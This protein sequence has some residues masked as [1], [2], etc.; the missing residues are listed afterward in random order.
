MMT[1]SL[2]ILTLA[3][4]VQAWK[5]MLADGSDNDDDTLMDP[6]VDECANAIRSFLRI[7][8]IFRDGTL[9]KPHRQMVNLFETYSRSAGRAAALALCAQLL[10]LLY[11]LEVK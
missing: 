6:D 1:R 10:D 5:A 8:P 9:L 7:W 4:L 3:T 2:Y 11:A